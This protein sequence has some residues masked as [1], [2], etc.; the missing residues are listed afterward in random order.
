M[1]GNRFE[2]GEVREVLRAQELSQIS[3][4]FGNIL[5]LL[6]ILIGAL[7][8]IPEKHFAFRAVFQRNQSEI[9]QREQ[10]FAMLKRVVIVLAIVFDRDC[11][12]QIAQFNHHLWIILFDCNRRDV[13]DH[14]FDFFQHVGNQ[15]GVIGRKKAAGFLNDCGIRNVFVV[16]DLLDRIND[17]VGE[18]LRVIICRRIERGL[19]SVVIHGHAAADI[20]QLDRNFH[21][22][23]FRIDARG[24]FHRVLDALDVGKLRTDVKVQQPQHLDS[25][26]FFQTI[27][28]L[29]QFSCSQPKLGGFTA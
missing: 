21:L 3:E 27:D 4:F 13:F 1:I 8:H 2:D 23:N 28:H 7:A 26:G 11:F 9:E 10:F 16:T 15:D 29:E 17:V 24:F 20:Q 22:I 14:R 25:S 18:F 6:G 5:R 12:A 19:R